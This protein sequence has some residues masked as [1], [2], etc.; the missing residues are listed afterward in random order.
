MNLIAFVS[1]VSDKSSLMQ[2]F[3]LIAMEKPV[4]IR[5]EHIRDEKVK[6]SVAASWFRS[7]PKTK[8]GSYVRRSNE[9]FQNK[10]QG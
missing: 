3:C 4:S 5:P 8:V 2:V 1:D 9:K 7:A 10:S 6:V